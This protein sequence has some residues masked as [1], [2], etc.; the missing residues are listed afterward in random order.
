MIGNVSRRRENTSKKKAPEKKSFKELAKAANVSPA[1]VSRVAKGQ[2]NVDAAIRARVRKT[3]ETLGIDLDQKRNEKANIIAFMLESCSAPRVIVLLRTGSFFSCRS[4][5]RQI[6]RLK[7]C[8][9]PKFSISAAS[10]A[11]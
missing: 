5:T 9:F 10:C 7:N 2:T 6:P 8:T 4:G 3:A 11:R 1:T